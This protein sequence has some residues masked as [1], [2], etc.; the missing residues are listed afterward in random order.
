[1]GRMHK[2]KFSSKYT[3]KSGKKLKSRVQLIPHIFLGAIGN[4]CSNDVE[5]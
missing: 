5:E 1:M 3:L 2:Q 4:T